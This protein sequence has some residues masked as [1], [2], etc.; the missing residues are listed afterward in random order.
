MVTT[1]MVAVWAAARSLSVLLLE[2]LSL[3][4]RTEGG[5]ARAALTLVVRSLLLIMLMILL[6]A[7]RGLLLTLQ[8][9]H[10]LVLELLEMLLVL[11]EQVLLLLVREV[12]G[13][14]GLMCA[15]E[16]VDAWSEGA[17]ALLRV[18]V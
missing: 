18:L 5:R 9:L 13:H 15:N 14:L 3:L 12:L 10:V 2:D 6:A 7:G 16:V 4:L 1:L 8:L 11:L 17:L